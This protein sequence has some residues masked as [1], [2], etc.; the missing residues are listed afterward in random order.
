MEWHQ[1]YYFQTVA[2]TQH[3]TKAAKELSISQPALSRAIHKLEIELGVKLFDRKGRNIFLN[4][5]G[6]MFLNRVEQAIKQIEIGKQEIIDEIH[7]EHGTISL[8]FLPSLGISF[9]PDILSNFRSRY[10]HIKFQLHQ[11]SNE[12]IFN[13]VKSGKVDLA[14]L[15]LLTTDEDIWWQPLLTEELFLIVS[16]THPLANYDEVELAMIK[17]E[18]FITFREGYGLRTIIQNFCMKAGL[19]PDIVFE[20]EDIGTVSGLVSAGLGVSLVPDVKVIDKSKVKLIR[21]KNPLCTRD[22]GIARLK[23][24]YLSPATKK[25]IDFVKGL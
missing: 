13:Q 21:V 23:N 18:P 20:G 25:F 15:T 9:V 2:R 7:P 1:I 11:A 17:G 14:F 6:K 3:I 8:A 10:P 12:E 5:Y 22:I 19:S 4:R 24:S 16:N